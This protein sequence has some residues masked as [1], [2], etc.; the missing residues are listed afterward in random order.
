MGIIGIDQ[1]SV[2]RRGKE[3]EIGLQIDL[4]PEIDYDLLPNPA[5]Q[6]SGEPLHLEW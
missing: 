1:Q 2:K 4:N 6:A 3:P 5:A